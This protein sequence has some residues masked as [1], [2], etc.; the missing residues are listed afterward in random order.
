MV[1]GFSDLLGVP[2]LRKRGIEYIMY[3]IKQI[4]GKCVGEK[5]YFMYY[6]KATRYVSIVYSIVSIVFIGFV[7]LYWM[8]MFTW[9]FVQN[10]PH[11]YQQV[12]FYISSGEVNWKFISYLIPQ[13][14][15]MACIA[16]TYFSIFKMFTMQLMANIRYINYKK[17]MV[18]AAMLLAVVP[19]TDAQ[20]Q[21]DSFGLA[22]EDSTFT[23]STVVVKAD[24]VIKK[25]DGI[26]II[27]KRTIEIVY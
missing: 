27:P 9:H 8:P 22:M 5:P 7:L 18:A 2:N 12:L 19:N 23:L 10:T 21:G 20:Q 17:I 14:L 4:F 11:W 26:T 15:F 24:K 13:L 6:S 1:T 3:C 16:I 25:N